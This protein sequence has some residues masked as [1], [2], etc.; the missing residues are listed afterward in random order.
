ML[1]LAMLVFFVH[2]GVALAE[3]RRDSACLAMAEGQGVDLPDLTLAQMQS[4]HEGIT[5]EV[6][7]VLGV[8][9]SIRSRTSFGGTAPDRASWGVAVYQRALKPA[10]QRRHICELTF[11]LGKRGGRE[12]FHDWRFCSR[13]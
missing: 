1:R 13:F 5:A 7:A 11:R 9:N 4:V 10:P 3:G 6:F 12:C 2:A 8:E